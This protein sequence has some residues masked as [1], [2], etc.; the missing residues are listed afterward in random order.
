MI[1]SLY[2]SN[3]NLFKMDLKAKDYYVIYFLILLSVN[4][5]CGCSKDESKQYIFI[6]DSLMGQL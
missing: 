1:L 6:G 2:L 3:K 4:V 5:F